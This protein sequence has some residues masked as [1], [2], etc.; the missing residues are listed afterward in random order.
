MATRFAGLCRLA[1]PAISGFGGGTQA[2]ESSSGAAHD[3]ALQKVE[4]VVKLRPDQ[5][6]SR[7]LHRRVAALSSN[8]KGM[9]NELLSSLS[10]PEHA[11]SNK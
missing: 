5:S 3:A 8:D 11:K 9:A 1:R 6:R 4:C 2:A 10:P 7:L